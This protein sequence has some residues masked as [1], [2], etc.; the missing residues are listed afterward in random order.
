M[1]IFIFL[2]W[3]IRLI[4]CMLNSSIF[5]GIV[6][7]YLR[8]LSLFFVILFNSFTL[9]NLLLL[10]ILCLLNCIIVQ[11]WCI[12]ICFLLDWILLFRF[13]FYIFSILLAPSRFLFISISQWG[14]CFNFYLI[15]ILISWSYSLLFISLCFLYLL[16]FFF[17]VRFGMINDFLDFVYL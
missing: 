14:I 13:S 8:L 2:W 3:L 17:L 4:L 6:F 9:F 16:G 12:F 10:P 1:L 11:K 5:I 7:L 15:F